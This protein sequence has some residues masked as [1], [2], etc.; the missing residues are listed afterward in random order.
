MLHI[1]LALA[2]TRDDYVVARSDKPWDE[3]RADVTGPTDD[4]KSH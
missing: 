2:S 4:D 3:E 1:R